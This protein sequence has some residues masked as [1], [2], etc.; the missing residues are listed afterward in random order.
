MQIR[1]IGAY[2]HDLTL[3]GTPKYARDRVIYTASNQH[4]I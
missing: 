3:T 4:D 2:P 1:A